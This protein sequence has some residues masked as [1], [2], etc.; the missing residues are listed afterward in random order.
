MH[1]Q[2]WIVH[3]CVGYRLQTGC[4]L[5]GT[6]TAQIFNVERTQRIVFMVSRQAN[7]WN[8]SIRI[9]RCPQTRPPPPASQST[10]LLRIPPTVERLY[11]NRPILCLAS[12]KILTPHPPPSPPGD[13]VYPPLWCGGRT[14]SLGG[15]W[16][17]G[18]QYF[19]RRETQLCTL[20]M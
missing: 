13:C 14:H 11:C 18:G 8:N 10:N 12:S 16:G 1:T 2:V 9:K 3:R 7:C 20:H 17:V 5:E 15:G 6:A 4:F 19:G